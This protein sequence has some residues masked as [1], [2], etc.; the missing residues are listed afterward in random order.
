MMA[1]PPNDGKGV[2]QP[3]AG[4]PEAPRVAPYFQVSTLRR[5]ATVIGEYPR[6][7]RIEGARRTL[8]E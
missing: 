8:T 1:G 5:T 4:P 2:L 7:L 3:A 6:F